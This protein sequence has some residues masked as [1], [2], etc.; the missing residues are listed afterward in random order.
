MFSPLLKSMIETQGYAALD[1][2]DLEAFINQ[3]DNVILVFAEGIKRIPEADDLAI[4][5]PELMHAFPGRFRVAVVPF[6]AHRDFKLKYHF[7]KL[8]SLLFLRNGEYVG[9]ISGLMDWSDYLD[10]INRLLDAEPSEPPPMELPGA[11]LAA[12]ATQARSHP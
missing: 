7:L 10:E 2:P 12:A 5:L 6:T 8:P 3:H 9:V 1:G 4:I 11:D